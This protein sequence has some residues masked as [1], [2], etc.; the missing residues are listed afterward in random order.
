MISD[1]IIRF[2]RKKK[3]FKKIPLINE[4]SYSEQFIKELNKKTSIFVKNSVGAIK[5]D[6]DTIFR[7]SLQ[8]LRK[9][10]YEYLSQSSHIH[11]VEDKFLSELNDQFN[12][13]ISESIK[14]YNQKIL[15]D[16]AETAGLISLDIIQFRKGIGNVNNFALNW[17]ATLKELF[18]KSYHKD[19]TIVCHICLEKINEVIL[20]SLDK[21]FYGSFDTYKNFLDELSEVLSKVNQYWAAILLQKLLLMYQNQFIKLLELSKRDIIAFDDFFVEQYF[22]K[23][24]KIIN[25]AKTTHTSFGNKTVILASV[26]GIDSFAQKIAKVNLMKLPNDKVKHNIT[27]YITKFIEFNQKIINEESDKNDPNVYESFS[28]VLYLLSE[29]VDLNDEDRTN[30]IKLLSDH[31]ICFVEK[32]R[33]Q[34]I[35][36]TGNRVYE[37]KEITIDYFAILI[38]L[39]NSNTELIKEII[40]KYL[41]SFNKIKEKIGNNDR[42]LREFYKELK[43][44]SCWINLYPSLKEINKPLIKVLLDHFYDPHFPDRMP[45]L[46]LFEQYGY[47]QTNISRLS[48]LWYLRPSYMW[49][50]RFQDAIAK[51][52]NGDKGDIFVKFHEMLKE[53]G[54]K[55]KINLKSPPR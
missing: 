35:S 53:R 4:V 25:E 30:R 23:F 26:Y 3:E 47:P 13:I 54:I 18:L 11:A 36:G 10:S 40:D 46:S 44:Y 31:L 42:I 45:I 52:L 17:V 2:I 20:L 12:F 50:N 9:I 8:N 38:Y 49:G 43:L 24:S 33:L 5:N 7:V 29:Y 14:S 41:A 37:E 32:T 55:V 21:G 51:E 28:E 48:D 16:V 6:Q 19:R 15:E 1:D 34:R 22:N 27:R 39:H